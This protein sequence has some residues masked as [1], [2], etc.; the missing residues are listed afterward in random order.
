LTDG[1][2]TRNRSRFVTGAASTALVCLAFSGAISKASACS[3]ELLGPYEREG[4]ALF[5][6]AA[7]R[8]SLP[9][10]LTRD[11]RGFGSTLTLRPPPFAQVVQVERLSSRIPPDVKKEIEASSGRVLIVPWSYGADCLPTSW[12][13]GALWTR[14]GQRGLFGLLL[15][16]RERWENGIPTLDVTAPWNV[17]YPGADELLPTIRRH[18]ALT[19]DDL[20]S[21]YDSIP[22]IRVKP[23]E[24]GRSSAII[25]WAELHPSLTTRQPLEDMLSR[26][27]YTELIAPFNAR[28]S[29]LAGTYRFVIQIPGADSLVLFGRT[30][31]YPAILLWRDDVA[32]DSQRRPVAGPY[33]Y[34]LPAAVA[35][36]T[37]GLPMVLPPV[38]RQGHVAASFEPVATGA[39]ST[40]WSGGAELIGAAM[41]IV[42]DEAM[43]NRLV[44]AGDKTFAGI[45]RVPNST[46]GRFVRHA[47]GSV[48]LHVELRDG[49]DVIATL[50]GK[51][52]SSV[53]LTK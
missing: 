28:E 30:A 33:G 37:S 38:A 1:V 17:P 12:T 27:R 21:L 16:E 14:P 34:Y 52:L 39:D 7:T 23:D 22:P 48:T 20:L 18:P 40:V 47:D 53:S 5:I 29:P 19:P 15:R 24:S 10:S 42:T 9:V 51:R 11:A 36:E 50:R 41:A 32:R 26:A 25:T 8:D 31:L 46:P 45:R 43:K 6:G 3:L 49:H 44:A 2:G 4:A 35:L 13:F